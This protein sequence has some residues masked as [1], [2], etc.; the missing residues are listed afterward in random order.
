MS[1]IF[2]GL[3]S[4]FVQVLGDSD[5]VTYTTKG[6]T[7]VSLNGIFETPTM[8]LDEGT[9]SAGQIH[10]MPKLAVAEA[11]LPA[12]RAQGDSVAIKGQSY[13]VRAV[14][15]DGHGMVELLLDRIG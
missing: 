14:L 9:G 4:I 10:E 7:V 13:I 3:A 2:D 11:D 6:G 5:P 15:P 12:G 8:Q 1:S